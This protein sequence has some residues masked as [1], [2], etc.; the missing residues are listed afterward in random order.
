MLKED[1]E[2]YIIGFFMGGLFVGWFVR[3][4]LEVKKLVF[5]SIVVNVMEWL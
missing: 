2:V 5:L 3:Y 1:D 4:Y